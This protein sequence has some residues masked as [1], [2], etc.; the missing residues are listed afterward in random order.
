M[1]IFRNDTIRYSHI[2]EYVKLVMKEK[3]IV[4]DI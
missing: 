2:Y 4:V 3:L 1:G